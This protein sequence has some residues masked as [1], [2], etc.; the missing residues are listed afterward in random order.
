[1]SPEQRDELIHVIS[2]SQSNAAEEHR[3][4]MERIAEFAKQQDKHTAE[5]QALAAVSRDLVEV[6][7]IH[8]RRLDRLDNLN[9]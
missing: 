9:P 4:A 2:Q 1:M 3:R 5:I 6:A 8:A 7:R